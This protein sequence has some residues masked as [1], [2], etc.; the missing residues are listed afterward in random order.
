MIKVDEA[1]PMPTGIFTRKYPY[2]DLEVGQSFLAPEANHNSI[3]AGASQYGKKLS[4][5][6]SVRKTQEGIRVWRVA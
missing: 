1:V 3:R 4:R 6:F 5:R 2:A